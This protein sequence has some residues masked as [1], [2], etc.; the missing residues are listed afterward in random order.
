MIRGASTDNPV[1][2]HLA[3]GPGG[4]G[5]GAMRLDESPTPRS[6]RTTP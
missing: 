4:T 1:L 2:L 6:S 3:G 5:I